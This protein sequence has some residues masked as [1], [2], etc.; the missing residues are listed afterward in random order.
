[1]PWLPCEPPRAE[2]QNA[3]PG[4]RPAHLHVRR[5][6]LGSGGCYEACQRRCL[7]VAKMGAPGRSV[8]SASM[9]G[10]SDE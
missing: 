1:M 3:K 10:G 8:L 5:R 6:P 7:G 4:C 9:G 2:A